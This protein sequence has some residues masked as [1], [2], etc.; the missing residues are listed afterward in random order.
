[1][2]LKQVEANNRM[3]Y[4]KK[5]SKKFSK[6]HRK[7]LRWLVKLHVYNIGLKIV[8]KFP[9]SINAAFS[10]KCLTAEFSKFSSTNVKIVFFSIRLGK[11]KVFRV[12]S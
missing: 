12:F 10:A 2:V 3:C 4:L 6:T 8:Q 1:M 9:K 11:I 5:Y 7:H